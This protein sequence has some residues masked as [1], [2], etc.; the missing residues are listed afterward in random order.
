MVHKQ[1]SLQLARGLIRT[2][3]VYKLYKAFHILP[4]PPVIFI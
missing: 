4:E 1:N 2:P 3:T